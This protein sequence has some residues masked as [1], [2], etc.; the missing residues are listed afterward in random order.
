MLILSLGGTYNQTDIKVFDLGSGGATIDAALVP[1]Y[2][3]TVLSVV[4]QVSQF[5]QILAPKP[6]GAQW[7]SSNSLF[8]IWIGINDIG[9]SFGWS[10]V[11]SEPAFYTTL[12][13][14]L[15]SQLEILYSEGARSFL[16]LTVPP[17]DR[18]PLW[19]EQG[20]SVVNKLHPLIANYNAQLNTLASQFKA[21]HKDI[22]QATVFDTQIIFNTLL[23]NADAL[24]FVNSTGYCAAY[25]NGTPDLT[26][27]ISPCAPVSSYFWLN[28][29]HPLFTIH[30]FVA[31][32]ISTLLSA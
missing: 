30:D 8:A 9:N 27:Q 13:N 21:K 6:A 17:V 1:P 20:P 22:D 32:G 25:E 11:T 5:K 18:A 29:L 14:R 3:P 16:F 12:M 2:L 15:E 28:T 24:G 7:N 23:D 10:N 26:T 19:N 4:D 31:R